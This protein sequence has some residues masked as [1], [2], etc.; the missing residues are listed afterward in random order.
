MNTVAGLENVFQID[1]ADGLEL[2]DVNP[3]K[4]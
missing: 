3:Q 2:V 4:M 1:L